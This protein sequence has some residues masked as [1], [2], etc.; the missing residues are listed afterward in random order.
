[1]NSK[2]Y[3]RAWTIAAWLVILFIL[4]PL[5]VVVLGS[6]TAQEFLSLPFHASLRWYADIANHPRFLDGFIKSLELG[7]A[8]AVLATLFGTL[9][10]IGIARRSGQRTPYVTLLIGHSIITLPYV[11]RAVT[12]SLQLMPRGLEWAGASLGAGPWRVIRYVVL[13][14]IAPGLI[15]GLIFSFVVSFDTVTLSVF[16]QNP[17]FIPLPVR[18][19]DFVQ[20]GVDPVL[21]SV[22]TLLIL[23]TTLAMY[24]A[25]RIAGSETL[26]GTK[27]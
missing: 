2:G 1:M 12:A 23:F 24:A 20:T 13:P 5:I 19:Y 14:N 27:S 17:S 22:S 21:A 7:V 6:F 9:A 15:G 26:F 16:L 3:Q 4:A 11:L 18:L 25:R 10:A 8:S